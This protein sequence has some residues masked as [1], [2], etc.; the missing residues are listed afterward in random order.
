LN[1]S[2]KRAAQEKY[3][4]ADR[5]V[6]QEHRDDKKDSIEELASQT[7]NAKGQNL[8]LITKKLAAKFRQTDKLDK[9][10]NPLASYEE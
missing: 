10:G 3:T 9:D 2:R 5:K 1:I 6:R 8:Y 7:E 4:A